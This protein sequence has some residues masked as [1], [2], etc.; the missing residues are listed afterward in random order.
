[1]IN[2]IIETRSYFY[3]TPLYSPAHN[4]DLNEFIIVTRLLPLLWLSPLFLGGVMLT[5]F[6]A[7]VRTNS[8]SLNFNKSESHSNSN[9][10]MTELQSNL[11]AHVRTDPL[12]PG[13][14]VGS[15][16]VVGCLQVP[17]SEII[18]K[19]LSANNGLQIVDSKF[20][21][22][23]SQLNIYSKSTKI[24]FDVHQIR[25]FGALAGLVVLILYPII[26]IV[27]KMEPLTWLWT[28]VTR[29]DKGMKVVKFVQGRIL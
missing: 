7:H 28:F 4:A 27:M 12:E 21:T 23:E 26:A 6:Q 13:Q 18:A 8:N 9:F 19:N 17:K 10:Y 16:K 14:I 2:Q 24:T 25:F 29:Y 3:I 11:N 1:M 20:K 15:N 5:V 22:A